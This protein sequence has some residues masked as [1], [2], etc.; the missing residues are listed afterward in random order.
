VY[1]GI[2]L[3]FA[4]WGCVAIN[5]RQGFGLMQVAANV[6]G[7]I[8]VVGGI[9]VLLLNHRVLPREIRSP[10]WQRLAVVGGVIFYVFFST[11]N[12]IG[13]GVQQKWWTNPF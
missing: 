1:Y 2:L 13:V 4:L 9:H 5:L 12:F 10:L 3:L 8:L 11:M 6:A 7:F